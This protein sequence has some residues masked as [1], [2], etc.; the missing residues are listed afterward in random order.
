MTALDEF[1]TVTVAE[2]CGEWV[3]IS[4][5]MYWFQ[6]VFWSFVGLF[7]LSQMFR[8]LRDLGVM[9]YRGLSG[10]SMTDAGNRREKLLKERRRRR[11]DE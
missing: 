11:A 10:Q 4:E 8:G 6:T 2:R 9:L 5:P 1:L 7:L 3:C